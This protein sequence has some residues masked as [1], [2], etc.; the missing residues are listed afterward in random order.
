MNVEYSFFHFKMETAKS[1]CYSKKYNSK[2]IISKQNISPPERQSKQQLAA[3]QKKW[4][5]TDSHTSVANC[6]VEQQ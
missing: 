4:L 5:C 3:K 1:T 2:P 6:C